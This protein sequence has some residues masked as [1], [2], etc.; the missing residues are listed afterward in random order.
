V[1]NSA[2]PYRPSDSDLG[3]PRDFEVRYYAELLWRRRILLA[4]VAVGGLSL[5]VLA[6]ELQVPR[7]QARALLQVM[8]PNPTSLS[9]TDALVQT[10]NPMRD[11]QFFNTQLNV[12]RSRSVALKVVRKLKLAGPEPPAPASSPSSPPGTKAQADD[13]P[14]SDVPVAPPVVQPKDLESP[15][16]RAA[17][18]QLLAAL[19]VEP[20]PDTYVVEVR[21]THASA[22]DAAL[23]ANTLAKL[24]M[25]FS[26]EGRV[27]A[28]KTAYN[29][30]T[31]RLTD[32]EGSMQQAQ[33]QL[34]NSM[35]GQD[36]FVPEGSVSA[37]T[38]SITKLNEDHIQAQTRRIELEAQLGEFAEM[39]RRGRNLDAIPQV[40][41]D[42]AV[43]QTN[44]KLQ[45][46][47]LDLARLRE[48]Y[49]EG[50]PEVQKVQV[51]MEQLRKDKT[52]RISQIEESLKAEYRQLQRREVELQQAIDAHKSRA[53]E[54]SQKLAELDSLKKKADS[55]SGLY[56]VLL[57]KLNE[58]NIAASLQNDNLRILDHA[59]VPSHPVWPRKRQ[60]AL[61]SFLAGLLLGA[62]FVLLRDAL[63]NT[64]KDA[65]DVER[66]L[67]LELLAA[68]PRY[69]KEDATLATE[70][71]QNLRTALL[72]SRRGEEGQ[73]ILITGTAPGEG[74]TT[75]LLNVAKLLSV[76]GEPAVVVD[77][78][79][80][81]ANLHLRLGIPREPGF[82]DFFVHATEIT[83]LVRTT[84]ITN[85]HA[86]PAGPLPPNPPAL[87]ARPELGAALA[88]L[89]RQYRWVLVDSPPVA[90]VTDAL[91]LARH[92]DSTV[93]VVQQ[94]KIDRAMVKRSL[95]ALRKVTPNVIGAVL[96]AVDVKTKGYYGYGYYGSRKHQGR[97]VP[98]SYS[99]PRKQADASS[100]VP[101]VTDDPIV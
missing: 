20:V 85:L 52:A 83:G 98:K 91:L 82:T 45:S 55:A 77:C 26:L 87:L 35:K 3:G 50:H 4:A 79:L 75:T 10:G 93:L 86:I 46:M 100:T 6:G 12:L 67:H 73:V 78:D 22:K 48:K 37:I 19:V 71:Y 18:D 39:R 49:K 42:A 13:S 21:I 59:V 47:A 89:K 2:P 69:G 38:T 5:G 29:W 7:Y 64:L 84:R 44:A 90:A 57:Q 27:E 92:A 70:A 24:Y 88:Q 53:A 62:G 25:D 74:K 101:E 96:N 23:W 11:R 32:T 94:N 97:K 51:Q 9:V 33:D 41:N 60:I 66:H 14:P 1:S 28:A 76:S 80:R 81:R 54:Q 63:D 30:V 34:L 58:T 65:D 15:A 72:F 8:P 16:E 99:A 40:G 68:I 95:A 17:V 43:A 31:E 36:L 61:V 56:A